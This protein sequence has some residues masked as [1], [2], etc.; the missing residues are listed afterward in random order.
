MH[1]TEVVPRRPGFWKFNNALLEDNNYVEQLLQG[2]SGFCEKYK[3]IQDKRM[4]WELL[5]MEIRSFTVSFA[6]G[7]A[8]EAK[9]RQLII[10]DE[11]DRLD[12]I[13]CTNSDVTCT[14]L[15]EELK[16]YDNLKK[17]LQQIYESK[18]EA[19]KFRSKCMWAEK[20]ERP[21][22]YF[23]NLKIKKLQ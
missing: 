18:G 22:K 6:K 8:K 3:Y 19:A 17:E 10:N 20:G 21:T 16:K 1:W 12:H 2:S 13:I 15:D 14:S 9:K 4:Y 7:K 5:K 11:M 23:F